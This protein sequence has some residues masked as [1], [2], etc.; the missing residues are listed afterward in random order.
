MF[1]TAYV[2]NSVCAHF[3]IFHFTQTTILSVEMEEVRAPGDRGEEGRLLE[4]EV[5]EG[6]GDL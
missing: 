2:S 5:K 6:Q 4:D 3:F 1:T